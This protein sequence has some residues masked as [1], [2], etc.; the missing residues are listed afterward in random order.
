MGSEGKVHLPRAG[1]STRVLRSGSGA[2][3]LLL[4]GSPDSANEWAPVMERLGPGCACL[5]PDLPGLGASDEPPLAF[6]YSR[7]ACTAFVDEVLHCAGVEGPVVLVVHDIG[8]IVGIPWAAKHVERVRGLVITNTVVFERFPWFLTGK[9]WGRTDALGRAA[10]TA[11]M[12]Q[13]GWLGGRIFRAGFKRISP[14][15]PEADLDRMTRE[16]ALDAKSK[17]STLRLFRRM[18]PPSYFDGYE[19]MVRDLIT[20]V[21]VRVIWGTGDPY[22]P[23]R[24]AQAFPGANCKVLERAGHW[25]PI[26]GAAEVAQAIEAVLATP[27]RTTAERVA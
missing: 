18:I 24:Y 13:F 1:F 4:H 7:E 11:L 26:S 5:A 10:A 2:D 21:P 15:L 20:R 23:A 16:F 8:G 25:V 14:E 6:D 27:A 9:I 12:A 22:I 19:A 17:R 3:V